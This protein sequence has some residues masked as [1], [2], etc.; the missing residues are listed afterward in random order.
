MGL[1]KQAEARPVTEEVI[2]EWN[3]DDKPKPPPPPPPPPPPLPEPPA[4]KEPPKVD[5]TPKLETPRERPVTPPPPVKGDFVTPRPP[6]T[7][8]NT[9]PAVDPN[10]R[11]ITMAD[12]SGVGKE[13]DVVGNVDPSDNRAP[14]GNT[15][16]A[17]PA[18]PAPPA[19]EKHEEPASNE[20]MEES[21]VDVRPELRNQDDVQR[22]L[23]RVYPPRLR[24][25]GV[26][27]E[28][29]LQ[30]VIGEDG[31]VEPGTV[32]VVSSSDEEFASAAR[33]VVGAMRFSPAKSKGR[34]VRVTTTMP[35]RWTIA[36]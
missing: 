22:Q 31:R 28:T 17:P 14:T 12:V 20:P 32:E 26:T 15:E 29:V 33:R 36:Q 21:A 16:P 30:F 27:G 18:P 19:E 7:T 1:A 35:V 24:D 5:M 8:P 10:A 25:N 11:P 13:G 9:L 23:E 4:P 6:E 2:A 34:T 3:L